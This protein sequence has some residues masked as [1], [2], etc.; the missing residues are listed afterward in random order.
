M[1][2]KPRPMARSIHNSNFKADPAASITV[3]PIRKR[4]LPEKIIA[5]IR[6]LIESGQ[7]SPGSRLPSERDFA[8]MLGVGR[9]ALREALKALAILGIIEHRH[10]VGVFLKADHEDWPVEPFSILLTLKKGAL[11]DAFEARQSLEVTAAT[12]AAARRS[13]SDIEA[14]DRALT[15]MKDNLDRPETFTRHEVDFHRA[16][17]AASGN[18]IIDDLMNKLYTLFIDARAFLYDHPDQSGLD[19]KVDFQEHVGIFE[20]VKAGDRDWARREMTRH[21][22]G[23]QTRLDLYSGSA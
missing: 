12:L 11:R 9:P 2:L 21:M 10:G 13:E 5:E 15:R 3:E 23:V 8:R 14:M 7:I 6:S 17:I 22:D 18:A 1:E 4:T 19:I 20:A 16:L